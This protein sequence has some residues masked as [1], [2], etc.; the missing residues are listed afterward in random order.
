MKNSLYTY[1]DSKKIYFATTKD[2]YLLIEKNQNYQNKSISLI[3]RKT[4]ITDKDNGL[5]LFPKNK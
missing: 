2:K 4:T 5:L 1:L 3:S